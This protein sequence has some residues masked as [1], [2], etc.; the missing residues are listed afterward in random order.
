MNAWT[1]TAQKIL[2]GG[3]N[4]PHGVHVIIHG[5]DACQAIVEAFR[6]ASPITTCRIDV[7]FDFQGDKA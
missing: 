7:C 1:L 5:G 2:Y 4:G 6:E 3:M